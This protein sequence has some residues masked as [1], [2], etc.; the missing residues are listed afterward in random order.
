MSF[1]ELLNAGSCDRIDTHFNRYW[2]YRR[3]VVVYQPIGSSDEIVDLWFSCVVETHR[4]WRPHLPY[5]E[6]HD[7]RQSGIT[8]YAINRAF[9][10]RDV[11]ASTYGRAGVVVPPGAAGLL[12]YIIV[13]RDLALAQQRMERR[14]FKDT[15]HA[16]CW[17]AEGVLERTP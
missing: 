7:M 8:R 9:E 1:Q 3:Q 14:A 16:L 13:N 2:L 15:D 12:M 6:I 5:L 17:V 4:D 11:L 10:L